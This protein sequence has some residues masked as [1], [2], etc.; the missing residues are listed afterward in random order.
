MK[1]PS[2]NLIKNKKIFPIILI[3]TA[4][5]AYFTLNSVLFIGLMIVFFLLNVFSKLLLSLNNKK[6]V[7]S[8]VFLI[9]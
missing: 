5:F 7:N 4:R 9:N 8:F 2:I 3:I 1:I 6:V